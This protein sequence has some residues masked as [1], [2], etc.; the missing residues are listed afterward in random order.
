LT[1]IRRSRGYNFEHRLVKQ[2]NRGEWTARRLGGSSTGL[3]DIVAVNNK[4]SILL[5][6]EAKSGTSN[7]I[8]VP[9]D[10]IGR[11]FVITEMFKVYSNRHIVLAFKF[12]RKKRQVISGEVRY[13]PRKIREYYKIIKFREYPR[14]FP[15]IKCNY[16]GD[17]YVIYNSKIKQVKL[18]EF[19]MPFKK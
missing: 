12:M 6:I 5:S 19:E 11:C 16:D 15:I 7:S 9:S 10:Q 18:K 8:Y 13:L 4:K 3:P 17:T 1:N 2:L 14:K